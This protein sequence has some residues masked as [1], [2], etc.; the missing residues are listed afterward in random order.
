MS[1][2]DT[3]PYDE[4]NSL[5]DRETLAAKIGHIL[6]GEPDAP[7]ALASL[8]V[9]LRQGLEGGLRGIN[10]THAALSLAVELSYLRSRTHTS[11]LSLYRL[12]QEGQLK[13]EDEPLRLLDA[14][15]ARTEARTRRNQAR[16]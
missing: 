16:G 15:I 10:R 8:F 7:D 1:A 2:P 12:S 13:V 5:I 3:K 11:A 9:E 6:G 4:E 14:A